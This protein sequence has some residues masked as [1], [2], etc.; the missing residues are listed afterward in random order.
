MSALVREMRRTPAA[1][2]RLDLQG[3]GW[4]ARLLPELLEAHV[5]PAP[6]WTLPPEQERRLMFGAVARYL[7]NVAGPSGTLL[8]LD[9]LQWADGDALTLL[10]RLVTEGDRKARAARCCG[11]SARIGRLRCAWRI[12]WGCSWPI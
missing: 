7:A 9:D 8:L 6:T 11:C 3:C 4:L 12:H 5:V 10:E 1:R 2:L